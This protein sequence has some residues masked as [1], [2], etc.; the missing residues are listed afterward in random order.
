[1]T[2]PQIKPIP[3]LKTPSNVVQ[4]LPAPVVSTIDIPEPVVRGARPPVV[5]GIR[6]PVVRTPDTRIDYPT[7]DVPTEQEFQGD[8]GPQQPQQ[9][10]PTRHKRLPQTPVINVGGVD[11]PLPEPG[12][13]V[14]AGSLAVVTTVVTLGATI[15][16]NQAKQLL[17]PWLREVT[18]TK[19]EKN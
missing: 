10:T 3:S 15:G 4:T 14:A 13:L 8:M 19:E 2:T 11:V 6:P 12:P 1:M 5:T 16:V 18:P 7:I 17:E 9:P